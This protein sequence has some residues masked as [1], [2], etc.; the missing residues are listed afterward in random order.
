MTN[1]LFAPS[2][3][4]Q[5]NACVNQGLDAWYAYTSGY[6]RAA[7]LI[8]DA[9]RERP[10]DQDILI[11]PVLFLWRHHLELRLKAIAR[12]ASWLLGQDWKATKEHDLGQLF[13]AAMPLVERCFAEFAETLPREQLAQ[14]RNALVALRSV[15]AQ[16]MA[17]RYPEDLKGDK[18]VTEPYHINFD[19]VDQ[20]MKSI[21]DV[22][23]D[24]DSALSVFSDWKQETLS[25]Y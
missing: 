10:H 11:F 20:Y 3:H 5:L 16:A 6:R 18:H 24:I 19:V 12:S 23:D 7:E 14:A 2:K 8:T 4:W 1:P 15:D 22:L 17:F 25:A 21:A 9:L 13:A